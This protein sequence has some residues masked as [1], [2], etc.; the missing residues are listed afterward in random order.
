MCA[1]LAREQPGWAGERLAMSEAQ[2]NQFF[3]VQNLNVTWSMEGE[4]AQ[5]VD[6]GAQAAGALD[7][8][9]ATAIMYLFHEGA[10]LGLDGG[11]LDLG[12]VRDST[13]N[14]TNDYRIFAENFQSTAFVGVESLRISQTVCPTGSSSLPQTSVLECTGTTS[15]IGS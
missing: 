9:P 8:W 14:K 1:D 4:P 10:F 11:V 6:F 13:L 12:L 5:P 7:N 15:G 3:E 2:I